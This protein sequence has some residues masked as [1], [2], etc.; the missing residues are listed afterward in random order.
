MNRSVDQKQMHW[1]W[2]SARHAQA[3]NSEDHDIEG[4]TVTA[5]TAPETP[6]AS[7]MTRM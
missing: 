3:Q 6:M 2:I 7:A 1:N 5:A 4:A